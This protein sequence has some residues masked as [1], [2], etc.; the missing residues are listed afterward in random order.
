MIEVKKLSK[1][2]N[3]HYIFQ[4]INLKISRGEMVALVGPS[5]VG[6]ST[7]LNIMGS[8]EPFDAGEV[9]IDGEKINYK[10][11]V[12]LLREKIGFLFQNYALIDQETVSKNLD[13][14]LKFKKVVNKEELKQQ[15]MVKVGLSDKM[16]HKIYELSGGEQQRVALAR[17]MLKPCEIILADEPTGA[18]DSKNRDMVLEFL[19]ELNHNGKTLV[20]VTHDPYVAE[21][22]DRQIELSST[23]LVIS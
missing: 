8:L 17:L 12:N 23:N 15:V 22:C 3:S 20:I 21:F 7:L 16:K 9:L 18:L 13:I 14:A 2:Y 11:N 6:K 4:D 10:D 1:K 19:K 5:G